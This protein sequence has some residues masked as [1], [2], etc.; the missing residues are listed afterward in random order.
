[1]NQGRT[2]NDISVDNKNEMVHEMYERPADSSDDEHVV[3]YSRRYSESKSLSKHAISSIIANERK[4]ISD[5][6]LQDEIHLTTHQKEDIYQVILSEM[7]TWSIFMHMK[8]ID[9]E[10]LWLIEMSKV[11]APDDMFHFVK[12]H[13]KSFRPLLEG[14]KNINSVSVLVR[15]HFEATDMNVKLEFIA[16]RSDARKEIIQL[17]SKL[18]D[19]EVNSFDCFIHNTASKYQ[20]RQMEDLISSTFLRHEK[21]NTIHKANDVRFLLV[22][23]V[24]G[25]T[26]YAIIKCR[27]LGGKYL[28]SK[29]IYINVELEGRVLSGSLKNSLNQITTIHV[30]LAPGRK[31]KRH[32]AAIRY[33]SIERVHPQSLFTLEDCRKQV[34]L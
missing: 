13:C 24:Y 21:S 29:A 4:E 6:T 2:I 26:E 34:F 9:Q 30:S 28:G 17:Y 3:N 8:P 27:V 7:F 11:V 25:E 16:K 20:F 14:N 32:D 15:Q 33:I 23:D 31:S 10:L 18:V 1:M 19:F 12:K 22:L 5:F